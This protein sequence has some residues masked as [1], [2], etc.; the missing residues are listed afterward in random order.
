MIAKYE[1]SERANEARQ[2]FM[3]VVRNYERKAVKNAGQ[4]KYLDKLIIC[5]IAV[6]TR[7]KNRVRSFETFFEEQVIPK[8]NDRNDGNNRVLSFVNREKN[9]QAF[10][11]SPY[12]TE[13]MSD[14]SEIHA[15]EVLVPYLLLERLL[16]LLEETLLS[17]L[18]IKC[19][20]EEANEMDSDKVHAYE[21]FLYAA[22]YYEIFVREMLE[23]TIP[24]YVSQ[25]LTDAQALLAKFR[26][27]PEAHVDPQ[28]A[29]TIIITQKQVMAKVQL[30]GF[31]TEYVGRHIRNLLAYT[32]LI[33][34][35]ESANVIR[36]TDFCP[37]V[38]NGKSVHYPTVNNFLEQSF[39]EETDVQ[40]PCEFHFFCDL[41]NNRN[42]TSHYERII[43]EVHK[44]NLL[45]LEKPDDPSSHQKF[46]DAVKAY[47]DFISKH[48]KAKRTAEQEQ[49]LW[50]IM[51]QMGASGKERA[52]QKNA[53]EL[54]PQP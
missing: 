47:V 23:K 48:R 9:I 22:A 46:A 17:Y 28:S 50:A 36:G 27:Q 42:M 51:D 7:T 43:C 38:V 26:Q 25:T 20:E 32:N 31:Y 41:V 33:L 13:S 54:S 14:R 44:R 16:E 53:H 4:L 10:L 19:S 12:I 21:K 45:P 37:K 49:E 2:L 3:D 1:K 11:S 40:D 29:E 30:C 39:P 52:C 6:S 34:M 8:A 5:E 18:A 24:S 35:I 15:D